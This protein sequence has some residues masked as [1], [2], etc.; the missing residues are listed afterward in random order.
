MIKDDENTQKTL[1]KP[2]WTLVFQGPAE[3]AGQ[4]CYSQ[5]SANAPPSTQ[6]TTSSPPAPQPTSK[7]LTRSAVL[8]ESVYTGPPGNPLGTSKAQF[9][10]WVSPGPAPPPFQGSSHRAHCMSAC[11]APWRDSEIFK[12]GLWNL[13][14][15]IDMES[16]AWEPGSMGFEMR[17]TW[18]FNPR[19]A[20][21]VL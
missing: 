1:P 6:D 10:S 13:H 11:P 14:P 4:T 12:Q 3:V 8:P 7:P 9:L 5:V 2:H 21:S 18:I 15:L 20:P 16:R 17:Q 19:A